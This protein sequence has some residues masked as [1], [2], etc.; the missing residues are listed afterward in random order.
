MEAN[1]ISRLIKVGAV[2]SAFFLLGAIDATKKE[3]DRT[4]GGYWEPGRTRDGKDVDW[5]TMRIGG[6]QI[7]HLVTHNPLTES[8]QMGNTMMRVALSKFRKNDEDEQGLTAG[9]VKAIIGLA[10]KAPVAS[11]LMRAG[12]MRSTFPWR[13]RRRACAATHP[14]H[15]REPTLRIPRTGVR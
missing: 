4:F 9:A 10:T 11:P 14:E 12:E 13:H 6:H 8:A 5:G 3:E 15:R 1:A 7:P 2:G